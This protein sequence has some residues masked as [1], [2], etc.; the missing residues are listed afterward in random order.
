ML[1]F[2]P[3]YDQICLFFR[4]SN[5]RSYALASYFPPLQ[6]GNFQPSSSWIDLAHPFIPRENSQPAFPWIDLAH[7][8]IPRLLP[9]VCE[10]GEVF[11]VGDAPEDDPLASGTFAQNDFDCGGVPDDDLVSPRG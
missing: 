5:L 9:G 11:P 2:R 1:D 7:P 6:I 3:L 8:F 10:S 4:Y